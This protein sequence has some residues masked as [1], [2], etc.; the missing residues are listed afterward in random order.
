MV[1]T[2]DKIA[3]KLLAILGQTIDRSPYEVKWVLLKSF[4]KFYLMG[5]QKYQMSNVWP[6]KFTQNK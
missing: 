3:I 5:H 1:I 4:L 2:L 6:K